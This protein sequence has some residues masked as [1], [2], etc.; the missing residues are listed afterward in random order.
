MSEFVRNQ[1]DELGNKMNGGYIRWQSQNIKKLRVPI[2]DS[3]P[4]DLARKLHQAYHLK[5]YQEINRLIN[6]DSISNFKATF[7][8]A[9]LF[10][11][12]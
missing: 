12:I 6:S 8:Q 4:S 11:K 7:V 1:L 3:I 2:I 10:D 5:D 9:T